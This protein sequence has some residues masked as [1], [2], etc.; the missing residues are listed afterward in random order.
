MR[1]RELF[2]KEDALAILATN[3]PQFQVVDRIIWSKST[4]GMYSVKTGY[5]A[6]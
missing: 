3:V 5:R 2:S 1:V 6:W 4:D